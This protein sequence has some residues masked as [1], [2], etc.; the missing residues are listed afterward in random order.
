[1]PNLGHS[2]ECRS[3]CSWI[4][5]SVEP[6][7]K[8]RDRVISIRTG[9]KTISSILWKTSRFYT[10]KICFSLVWG[11][12][13]KIILGTQKSEN[14]CESG[15]D[16]VVKFEEVTLNTVLSSDLGRVRPQPQSVMS[17]IWILTRQLTWVPWTVLLFDLEIANCD[18]IVIK[19]R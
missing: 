6:V 5:I 10:G 14:H 8:E 11:T 12:I 19:M 17:L 9:Q 2:S 7:L 18:E 3:C 16:P 13:K 15:K 1:M 4:R